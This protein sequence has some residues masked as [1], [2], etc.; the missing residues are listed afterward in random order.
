[1]KEK[2]RTGFKPPPPRLPARHTNPYNIGIPPSS[3]ADI[4]KDSPLFFT[5]CSMVLSSGTMRNLSLYN[6]VIMMNGFLA[7]PLYSGRLISRNT[8]SITVHININAFIYI[9]DIYII[10]LTATICLS[11]CLSVSI[12][13]SACMCALSVCLSFCFC[14]YVCLYVC[15]YV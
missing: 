7:R 3:L 15:L 2:P 8:K 13:V 4:K 1:M 14:M 5:Y 9:L 11:L 10:L 12:S 6:R